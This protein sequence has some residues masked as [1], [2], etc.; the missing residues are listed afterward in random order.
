M[1][2]K[3]DDEVSN[4]EWD[5]ETNNNSGVLENIAGTAIGVGG[6]VIQSG[7]NPGQK[8]IATGLGKIL[9]PLLSGYDFL[10]KQAL[11]IP[12]VSGMRKTYGSAIEKIA[13]V[14][15]GSEMINTNIPIRKFGPSGLERTGNIPIRATA[16]DIVGGA[17]GAALDTITLAGL[18]KLVAPPS[19][20]KQIEAGRKSKE[21]IASMINV[22]SE[23][24]QAT[25]KFGAF[26]KSVEKMY[27]RVKPYK[28]GAK[29][30]A[31]NIQADITSNIQSRNA[32][33]G[34]VKPKDLPRTQL[35][36]L[37]DEIESLRSEGITKSPQ[38]KAMSDIYNRE[39]ERLNNLPKNAED[40]V[41][42]LQAS[43][44]RYQ[45]LAEPLY[46]KARFNTITD[47]ESKELIAYERLAKGYQQ[48]IEELAPSVAKY[49]EEHSALT[50][51]LEGVLGERASEILK[52]EPSIMASEF[53]NV[54]RPTPQSAIMAAPRVATQKLSKP[55]VSRLSK[56]ASK[57]KKVAEGETG[58]KGYP[59][60]VKYGVGGVSLSNLFNRKKK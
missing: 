48:K 25:Q 19:S 10:K 26:P 2:I 38:L 35:R 42:F 59:G 40:A 7:L 34:R 13:G 39:V 32:V 5:D 24:L 28:G 33:L 9:S 56:K 45:G 15:P 36:P 21:A 11:N 31:E 8:L 20:L 1:E 57:L 16:E 37:Y 17:Q 30:L 27:E 44:E 50:S 29:E 53:S 46:K 52:R 41:E 23:E 18:G 6:Q 4:I 47:R 43:K 49:N 55:N 60:S 51:A 3:W 12:P 22:P 54:M 58:I 14:E